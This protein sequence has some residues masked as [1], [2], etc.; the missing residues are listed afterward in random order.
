MSTAYVVYYTMVDAVAAQW[1]PKQSLLN[2]EVY[3][4]QVEDV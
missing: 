3:D 4:S 1:A 2:C